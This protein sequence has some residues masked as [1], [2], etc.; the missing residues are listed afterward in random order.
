MKLKY[1]GKIVTEKEQKQ[2]GERFGGIS[3]FLLFF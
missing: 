2:H 3:Y 1:Q